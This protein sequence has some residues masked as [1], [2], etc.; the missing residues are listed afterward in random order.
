MAPM[1]RLLLDARIGGATWVFLLV[2][3]CQPARANV[4]FGLERLGVPRFAA[5]LLNNPNLCASRAAS[6]RELTL[7]LR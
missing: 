6:A 5:Y 7:S 3:V 4:P 2:H 1:A